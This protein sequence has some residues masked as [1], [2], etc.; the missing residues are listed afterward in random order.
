MMEEGS[1][2]KQKGNPG[3]KNKHEKALK[4]EWATTTTSPLLSVV[5]F[6]NKT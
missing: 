5:S 4:E 2:K 1:L 3:K 6:L